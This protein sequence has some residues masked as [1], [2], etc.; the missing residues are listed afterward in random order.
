M[1]SHIFRFIWHHCCSHVQKNCL[2][3]WNFSRM[4]LY[5]VRQAKIQKIWQQL[6]APVPRTT[7]TKS[8]STSPTKDSS[9]F[10]HLTLGSISSSSLVSTTLKPPL[11]LTKWPNTSISLPYSRSL[12][13]LLRDRVG[14][15]SI[16]QLQNYI[17]CTLNQENN[18]KKCFVM[19]FFYIFDRK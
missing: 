11:S 15:Q 1:V 7:S 6:F 18:M 2:N 14:T 19:T 12:W 9:S 17:F 8:R 13:L 10:P 3:F 4:L 16:K 5:Y